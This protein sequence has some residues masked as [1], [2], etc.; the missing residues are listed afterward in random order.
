MTEAVIVSNWADLLAQPER[1][2]HNFNIVEAISIEHDSKIYKDLLTLPRFRARALS[3]IHAH[4]DLMPLEKIA[5]PADDLIVL[6]LPPDATASLARYCGVLAYARQFV[7]EI[8]AAKIIHLRKY[9]DEHLWH[10]LPYFTDLDLSLHENVIDIPDL[11][12]LIDRCGAICIKSWLISQ[13]TDLQNWLRLGLGEHILLSHCEDVVEY[14]IKH[15]ALVRQ[16]AKLLTEVISND[17]SDDV[18][19]S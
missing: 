18:D 5:V 13:D 6:S 9:I 7:A 16:A 14:D 19:A 1:L 10:K 4:Y 15:L 3:L 17:G 2:L 8:R 12:S 11:E